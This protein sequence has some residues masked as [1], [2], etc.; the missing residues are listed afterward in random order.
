MA[1]PKKN[2]VGEIPGA[3]DTMIKR[4]IE[5]Y[6][7]LGIPVTDAQI[8]QIRKEAQDIIEEAKRKNG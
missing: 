3:V 8:E 7:K 6:K 2:T 4:F 1:E 5:A